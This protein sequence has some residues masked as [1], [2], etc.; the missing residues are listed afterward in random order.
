MT[1]FK[2]PTPPESLEETGLDQTFLIGLAAKIM[3]AL[4]IMT[5]ARLA[6]EIKLPRPLAR[7]LVEE[8]QHLSLVESHGLVSHGD[9]RSDIRYGLTDR[10]KAWAADA[11][12]ASQYVGPAPVTLQAF[13]DQVALQ[14]ITHEEV[15]RD[16]LEKALG[17]L[18]LPGD[19]IMQLGPA[20]NS[21]R[22]VLLYGEAGNGKTSIAEALG[23]TLEDTLYFPHAIIVGGQMIKFYDETIH[24]LVDRPDPETPLDPRWVACKR[25]VAVTGGEL[26]L[27]MLDLIFDR[28]SRFYEAPVHLKAVGGVFVVDDF[29]RQ[30]NTP[31]QLLNRWIVPLER[32][33]DMLSLHTGQKFQ[34]PF[35]QLV[36]FSTNMMPEEMADAA[37]LRRL[38]FKIF[39]PSPT[40][41]DYLEIFRRVCEDE[42]Q[43]YPEDDIA[44][45][46][47]RVYEDGNLV[48]SGAHPGFLFKHVEAA[49]AF[50]GVPTELTPEMLDLAWKNVAATQR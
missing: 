7:K 9:I 35:D 36:I 30:V 33:F 3:N 5:P 41:E 48:T 43:E 23:S 4:G 34:V 25:P 18:V 12:L 13:R 16:K 20:V 32:G 45:F 14:S 22:S 31:Q 19:L 44:R 42:N 27:E 40:K 2:P 21:A 28:S 38:Y 17:K 49:C 15:H 10:G 46:Y 37:A 8:M 47:K 1:Y 50:R 11:M 24:E 26:T 29:G 6:D 39:V